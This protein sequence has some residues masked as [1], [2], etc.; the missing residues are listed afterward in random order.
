M[1]DTKELVSIPELIEFVSWFLLTTVPKPIRTVSLNFGNYINRME[2]SSIF[3]I[4][5]FTRWINCYRLHC[6]SVLLIQCNQLP[7]AFLERKETMDIHLEK[8]NG[9]IVALSVQNVIPLEQIVFASIVL[10]AEIGTRYGRETTHSH[11]H[12]FFVCWQWNH[13]GFG[14]SVYC[15]LVFVSEENVLFRSSGLQNVRRW[16]SLHYQMKTTWKSE[17]TFIHSHV[18]KKG[19]NNPNP[20]SRTHIFSFVY[21]LFLLCLFRKHRSRL[22]AKPFHLRSSLHFELVIRL[23]WFVPLKAEIEFNGAACE[24]VPPAAWRKQ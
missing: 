13:F 22:H 12:A 4:I 8:F 9:T 23:F 16:A 24:W 14:D 17:A 6:F 21:V 10:N 2:W 20:Y 15:L 7:Q 11:K 19:K 18:R 5:L 3:S 1:S